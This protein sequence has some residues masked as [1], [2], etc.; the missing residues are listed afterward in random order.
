[1]SQDPQVD[2]VVVGFG[3]AGAAAAI[4]VA[5]VGARVLVVDCGVPTGRRLLASRSARRRGALRAEL[6]AAALA[7]GAEVW[8]QCRV[9]E[10]VVEAGRVCGIGYAVLPGQGSAATGHRWLMKARGQTPAIAESLLG[11]VAE[12]V[13]G[14]RFEVGEVGCSSVVLALAPRHWEFVGA[15]TWSAV[16]AEPGSGPP[17]R[18]ALPG[19]P[20]VVGSEDGGI[21]PNPELAVR[22]W[23]AA[24]EGTVPAAG[25]LTELGVDVASGAVLL[26]EDRPVP[27]LYSAVPVRHANNAGSEPGPVISGAERAGRGAADMAARRSGAATLSAI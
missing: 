10:L 20:S 24:H 4:A 3:L 17:S 26:N 5:D 2:V 21:R 27:G 11:R 18:R 22:T 19:R 8:T 6:R 7:A 15:A 12:A 14:V 25:A 13:W 1:M 9:H 16:S 23:C